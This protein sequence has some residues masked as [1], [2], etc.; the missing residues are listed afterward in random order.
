MFK[1][2]W[3][4]VAFCV[5]GATAQL[6]SAEV[7]TVYLAGGGTV[8]FDD[9]GYTG[10][11]GAGWNDF[12]VP[13]SGGF[14]SARVGQVQHV[15][16]QT[17]DRLTPDASMNLYRDLVDPSS[18][19]STRYN[20]AN[21]DGQVNFYAWGYTTKYGSTFSNMQIDTQGN[22]NVARNDMHFA[23]YDTFSYASVSGPNPTPDGNYSTSISF[24]P[25]AISDALGWCGSV[26]SSTAD[27]LEKMAG[28]VKFDFA[29]DA[30][31]PWT[32]TN[33]AATQIV[34]D[35]VMRSYG[36][37]TVD[38]PLVTEDGDG[39]PYT[40]N[41]H[42]EASAVINNTNPLT[43]EI[44]ANY[45]GKVSFMGGG[46]VPM[47]VWL[48]FDSFNADGSKKTRLDCNPTTGICATVLDVHVVDEGTA[49]AVWHANSFGGYAFLLRADGSRILDFSASL[50]TNGYNW[51]DYSSAAPVPLPAAAWLL[52][53]GLLALGGIARRRKLA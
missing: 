12:S 14:N 27:A 39:N 42:Y 25:Y 4:W 43:G 49:G 28:Q 5:L 38:V 9:W 13:S 1:T 15:I 18:G 44:D 17:P 51:S 53:S 52:G 11:N 2:K 24:Q 6:A 34:P 33:P 32:G 29:F 30:K 10:P 26:L 3:P 19:A 45:A 35:F 31:F 40:F 46:V 36:T 50:E 41:Q 48:S 22:Y 21:M 16:T 37:L 20:N 47:G 8:T 7:H 23:K